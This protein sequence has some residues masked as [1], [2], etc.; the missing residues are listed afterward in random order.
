MS[1]LQDDLPVVA[2]V[3]CAIEVVYEA[4]R[5]VAKLHHMGGSPTAS[6]TAQSALRLASRALAKAEA[7]K[8]EDN[9][10][11]QNLIDHFDVCVR[12]LMPGVADRPIWCVPLLPQGQSKKFVPKRDL[13]IR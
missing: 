10:P 6:L 4:T 9:S 5:N 7:K 12:H 3:D 2:E 11:E 1:D 13:K 8:Q